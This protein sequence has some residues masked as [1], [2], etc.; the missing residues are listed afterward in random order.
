[1]RLS[2]RRDAAQTLV[3]SGGEEEREVRL[4]NKADGSER[5]EVAGGRHWLR[6]RPRGIPGPVTGVLTA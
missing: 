6:K 4:R 5:L 2:R 1:M 3:S